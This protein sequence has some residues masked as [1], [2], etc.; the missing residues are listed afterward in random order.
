MYSTPP[1][2]WV[3]LLSITICFSQL[4]PST[5]V[6]ASPGAALGRRMFN[7]TVWTLRPSIFAFLV[8]VYSS[9]ISPGTL[10]IR[11]SLSPTPTAPPANPHPTPS[12]LPYPVS[13][14]FTLHSTLPFIPHCTVLS[15]FFTPFP[16]HRHLTLILFLI[17]VLLAFFSHCFLT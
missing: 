2:F 17:L 14:L 5:N 10:T 12:S 3:R 15:M 13:S 4:L 6:I 11:S 16:F 7:M 8:N 1:T 9:S